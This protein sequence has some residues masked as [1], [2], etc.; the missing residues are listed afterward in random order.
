MSWKTFRKSLVDTQISQKMISPENTKRNLNHEV[1][2]GT[3][4]NK[5][6]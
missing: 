1:G 6:K 4:I 3:F 5:Y 2:E